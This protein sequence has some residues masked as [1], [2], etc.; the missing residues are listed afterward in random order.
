MYGKLLESKLKDLLEKSGREPI[1]LTDEVI[2]RFGERCKASIRKKFNETENK[3]FKLRMSN[4]G[5]DLRSLWLEKMY[6]REEKSYS[7]QLKLAYGDLIE[8]LMLALIESLDGLPEIKVGEKVSIQVG[9]TEVK[10]SY[11]LSIGGYIIDVKTASPYAYDS[12]FASYQDLKLNDDFGYIEQLYGY[13]FGTNGKELPLGWLTINKVNG[14]FKVIE[15]PP[16]EVAKGARD[17]RASIAKK[18]DVLVN[19]KVAQV[20]P[21]S[22]VEPE[23]WRGK[24]TGREILGSKCTYC[25]CKASCHPEGRWLPSFVSKAKNMQRVLYVKLLGGE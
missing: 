20:P 12:K 11:D 15:I 1:N 3:G 23:M 7:T 8:N 9:D 5:K 14:E 24:A 6:G 4:I 19:D 25:S 18:V 17:A 13:S 16:A 22:G 10:G 21:C 2:E